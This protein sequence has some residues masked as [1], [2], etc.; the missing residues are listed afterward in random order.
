MRSTLEKASWSRALT[1]LTGVVFIVA[2]CSGNGLSGFSGPTATPSA[3]CVP[4]GAAPAFVLVSPAPFSKAVGSPGS[5]LVSTAQ[6]NPPFAASL[7]LLPPAGPAV[8]GSALQSATPPPS[9]N[10]SLAYYSAT[11]PA[12]GQTTTYDLQVSGTQYTN[13][14]VS[15]QKAF[16]SDLAGL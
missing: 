1:T 14:P 10:T 9:G 16:V 3:P 11:F 2:G 7:N 4:P 8:Q 15:C 5:V 13:L 6:G 12:L